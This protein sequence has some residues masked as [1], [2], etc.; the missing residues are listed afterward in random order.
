MSAAVSRARFPWRAF[1]YL[2]VILYLVADLHWCHGPLKRKMEEH[3]PFTE[4]S[5]ARAQASGWVATVNLE[6]ITGAQLDQA[7][8]VYL[9]R[10]GKQWDTMAPQA[11]ILA[12]RA[13]L[14]QLIEDTIVRQFATA[15]SFAPDPAGVDRRLA[16][17][18][19]QFASPEARDERL[20]V[21]G[22]DAASLRAELTEQEKQRQW[23]EMR[24]A[25]AAEVTD[26]DVAEWYRAHADT[27]EG[28]TNPALVRARHI[29]VAT[30]V[31]DTP[32]REARIRECQRLL[33]S[34][35]M[36]FEALAAAFSDD[37]RTKRDGGDL[38]WFGR[39]RMPVPF[40]DE[41][42]K[43]KPGE[44]SGPFRSPL[45]WHILEV[46]N[47]KPAEKLDL[48]VL[49][50]EIRAWLETERRRYALRVLLNRLRIV[51]SVEVFAANF[52]R[53]AS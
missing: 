26:E 7:T 29:F 27:D 6:P 32:E 15:E 11:R 31:E 53:P 19:S 25:D 37:E 22:L 2:S 10:K 23:L 17:F 8:A 3:R 39:D 35:E 47:T 18:E 49:K 28:T 51:S 46:T 5:R 20:K 4:Y 48:E 14:A 36:T 41:A 9:F 33:E 45:G 1:L 21:M 50:P 43:M 42:F 34:G 52:D 38:G 24:I 30:G 40:A 13:A 44:R 16:E 12:K